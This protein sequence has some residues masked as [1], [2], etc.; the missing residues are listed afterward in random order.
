MSQVDQDIQGSLPGTAGRL[1][2]TRIVI[3]VADVFERL[4][5]AEPVSQLA[6]QIKSPA[7]AGDGL[8]SMPEVLVRVTQTVEGMRLTGPV[9]ELS[10]Q[11]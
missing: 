2:V 3:G 8:D 6:M 10:Q 9:I 4:R 1:E 11:G 7:V 5:L